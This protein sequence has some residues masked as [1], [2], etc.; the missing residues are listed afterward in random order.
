[1]SMKKLM[2]FVF[3]CAGLL[4]FVACA[5]NAPK[6]ATPKTVAPLT[7]ASA[8]KT[9]PPYDDPKIKGDATPIVDAIDANKDGKMTKEEWLKAGAPIESFQMFT[10]KSKKD[11]VT[12]QE[13]IDETPPNGVDANCDGKFTIKEFHD[14]GLQ[15]PPG[16]GAPGGAGG[17]PG[18]SAPA[19]A[20]PSGGAPG[21][22]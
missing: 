5:T 3:I 21:Q 19:G 4:L 9:C 16:G 2:I 11:Y 10:E 20:P 15:G 14:F 22:K 12:R 8:N 18:G 6:V 17:A 13:F 7:S 1:M